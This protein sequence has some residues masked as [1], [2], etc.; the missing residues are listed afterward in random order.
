MYVLMDSDSARNQP[1]VPR[2]RRTIGQQATVRHETVNE[3]IVRLE[4]A[5]D[6]V[7]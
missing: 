6:V 1:F 7:V 3:S 5:F 2:A 4:R